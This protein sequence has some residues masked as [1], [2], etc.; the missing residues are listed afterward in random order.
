MLQSLINQERNEENVLTCEISITFCL[1][2][3]CHLFFLQFV[4][5]GE[6]VGLRRLSVSQ[7]SPAYFPLLFRDIVTIHSPMIG[8]LSLLF[9]KESPLYREGL[10][11]TDLSLQTF[12]SLLP[13]STAVC[14]LIFNVYP[15]YE[16]QGLYLYNPKHSLRH[17]STRWCTLIF[18]KLRAA[19]A[20]STLLKH[21]DLEDRMKCQK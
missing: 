17:K 20:S 1:F 12:L 16:I 7:T 5:T 2:G 11:L 13:S 8:D 14:Y 3:H 9:F 4:L 10:N 18:T 19:V 15:H 21:L 6:R